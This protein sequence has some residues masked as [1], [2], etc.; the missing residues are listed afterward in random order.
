[1]GLYNYYDKKSIS[2]DDDGTSRLTMQS[3]GT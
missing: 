1:M 2:S 3:T